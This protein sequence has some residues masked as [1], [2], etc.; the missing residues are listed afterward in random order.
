MKRRLTL[1]GLCLASAAG[2]AALAPAPGLA[3]GSGP[4]PVAFHVQNAHEPGAAR[5]VSGL[6]YDPPCFYSTTAV[7]LL[8]GLSYTKAVWDVAGH[9]VARPLADAGYTVFA[10]DRLGYGGSTLGS[11][12]AVS[13]EAQAAMVDDIVRYMKSTW[14]QRVALVG[15]SAGAEVAELAAGL[16]DRADALAALGYHHFPSRQLVVDLVTGDIPRA[17]RDDFAYFLGTPAH[18]REMFFSPG[19]EPE[20]AAADSRAAVPSPSGE[21]LSFSEQPSGR[22]LARIEAPVLLQLGDSDLLFE[23]AHLDA[24]RRRFARSRS[25]AVDLV[26]EAG[27]SLMLHRSGPAATERL[28]GWLRSLGE[29]PPCR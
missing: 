22:V 3:T 17:A 2:A 5:Q 19:A 16:H 9:S 26:P 13:V 7:V 27:H 29:T 12:H 21:I 6:R 24:E 8:H 15:H 20:V 25:V 10:L 1:A 18:R 14:F 28:V 23:P 11:G 4:E